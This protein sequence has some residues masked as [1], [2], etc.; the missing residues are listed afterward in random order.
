MN[1]E[2]TGIEVSGE[3]YPIK[4]DID[5]TTT[6]PDKTWSSEKINNNLI[7]RVPFSFGITEDGQYGYY[8]ESTGKIIPFKNGSANFI[9]IY[10]FQ[11]R[12]TLSK[13]GKYIISATSYSGS[14]A[15]V[16]RT[17]TEL[18]TISD[19]IFEQ[20]TEKA[21]NGYSQRA[22]KVTAFSDNVICTFGDS[23]NVTVT[24]IE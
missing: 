16:A 19:G 23:T 22:Y 20:L 18:K 15:S 3:V 1:E 24:K 7:N 4:K 2:I 12:V 6:S 10:V 9:D 13:K 17:Y 11:N 21:D 14:G 8:E 5:D